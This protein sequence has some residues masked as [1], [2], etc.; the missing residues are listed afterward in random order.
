MRP[1]VQIAAAPLVVFY[2]G[3]YSV[4]IVRAATCVRVFR[5]HY[6]TGALLYVL[7]PHE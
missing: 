4:G 3:V 2:V 1:L 5:S 7:Y 6:H